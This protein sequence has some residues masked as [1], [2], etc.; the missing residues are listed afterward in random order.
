[1]LTL[2]EYDGLQLRNMKYP[3]WLTMAA[4]PTAKIDD[5]DG[6]FSNLK[7]SWKTFVFSLNEDYVFP[8]RA[9]L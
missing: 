2:L 1:M 8:H 7:S 6:I 4:I 5:P 3:H 9:E